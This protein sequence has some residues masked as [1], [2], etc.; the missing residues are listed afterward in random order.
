MEAAVLFNEGNRVRVPLY[1]TNVEV[2]AEN[3]E[4]FKNL[5]IE[6]VI[7]D[8]EGFPVD[9]SNLSDILKEKGIEILVID[10]FTGLIPSEILREYSRRLVT[11]EEGESIQRAV[12]RNLISAAPVS[13][14]KVEIVEGPAESI[15]I[16]TDADSFD[17]DVKDSDIKEPAASEDEIKVGESADEAW[18]KVLHLEF[19]KEKARQVQ[20]PPPVNPAHIED[21][22]YPSNPYQQINPRY[23]AAAPRNMGP[24]Y[25]VNPMNGNQPNPAKMPPNYLLWSVLATVFCCFIPGIVGIFFSSQVSSRFFRGDIAGAEKAS[26][27]AQIW[28]IVSFVLGMITSTL[29]FPLM[30]LQ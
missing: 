26:R 13:E 22:T 16:E 2:D 7:I 1:M 5:N 29:Y 27:N 17:V 4:K 3:I 20:T 18:S 19:D 11:V 8:G 30:L 28:I 23:G 14:T 10:K 6:V 12:V 24:S 9:G 25:G 21:A 15:T